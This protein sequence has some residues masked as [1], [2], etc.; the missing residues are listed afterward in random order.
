MLFVGEGLL[1]GA[2]SSFDLLLFF[3]FFEGILIWWWSVPSISVRLNMKNFSVNFQLNIN[4]ALSEVPNRIVM[5]NSIDSVIIVSQKLLS[6][7]DNS[8]WLSWAWVLTCSTSVINTIFFQAALI[9]EVNL[10]W[11]Q[12][13]FI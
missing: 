12:L 6:W 7:H 13:C 2:F 9:T 4:K 5:C 11:F 8:L 3:V 10:T 1:F